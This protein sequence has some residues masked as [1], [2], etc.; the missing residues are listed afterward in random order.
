[1]MS[2]D[3]DR[4]G[5]GTGPGLRVALQ[6]RPTGHDAGDDSIAVRVDVAHPTRPL[7]I[8]VYLDG[9]LMDTWV[10]AAS[11][12]EVELRDVRGRH[13]VTARAVDASGRWGGASTLV[14]VGAA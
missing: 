12:E 6:V 3:Q 9:R 13:V 2:Q 10:P 14:E 8:S 11:C 5:R 1:M 4:N 7:R